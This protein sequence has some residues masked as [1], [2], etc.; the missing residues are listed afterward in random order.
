MNYASSVMPRLYFTSQCLQGT[1]SWNFHY[2]EMTI[3]LDIIHSQCISEIF[4]DSRYDNFFKLESSDCHVKQLWL[5]MRMAC[6]WLFW[7]IFIK[8][9]GLPCLIHTLFFSLMIPHLLISKY[10]FV[11]TPEWRTID[12]KFLPSIVE[13]VNYIIHQNWRFYF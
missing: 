6:A 9:F 8:P 3:F 7:K 1:S 12:L 13:T 10:L 5:I 2:I 4:K 11:F